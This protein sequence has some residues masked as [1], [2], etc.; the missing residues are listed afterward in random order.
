MKVTSAAGVAC[1]SA[2]PCV[3]MA[4]ESPN[5][6]LII[7]DDMGIEASNCY[8][9]GEQQAK[10]PNIESMCEQ[11]MVFE[12][13]Y[14]APVCSPTRATIMTGEYGFRNGV[15]AAIPRRG[16]EGRG[17]SVDSVSLFDVLEDSDYS[18]NVIG[19]WHL[20]DSGREYDHP[21]QLGVPDYWGL[22]KGGTPSYSH[23]S[24][25]T[26]GKPFESYVYTT[27][28]FT[29]QALEWIDKQDNPWFLWLAYNAPHTPFHL[30]PL[31]LHTSDDLPDDPDA[32]KKT[33]LPYYNAM[34]EAMDTEIGRLLDSMDAEERKN[35][36]VMFVGDNGSPNQV[37]RGFYG[38]HKA[39]GTI[40]EGGTHV[41][42]IA[43]G[44]GVKEGR[45]EG[46][47]NTTD[48]YATVA[49]IAGIDVDLTDSYDFTPLLSG[50]AN[51]RDFIYVGH[52][53]EV[54]MSKGGTFGW[55]VREG[56]Y[57]SV[58][59]KGAASPELYDLSK[60][61]RELTD[62]LADGVSKKE[63]RIVNRIQARYQQIHG[64]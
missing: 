4:N 48:I 45:T 39:K 27:T 6:L 12:S 9:L 15:G 26:Q 19:K 40:Y 2:L 58:Q 64:S 33:P 13:A 56:D 24:G 28:D 5:V 60:D 55:A 36:I 63:Q 14:S 41:P 53:E 29:N 3:A 47:V 1:L 57:K 46:F 51:D 22:L 54:V 52:F 38:D 20:A 61:P 43:M 21:I 37:V 17:L 8:S 10:M 18:T 32:I 23:W 31:D 34:L 35:T 11:G 44:P 42:L 62:L 50:K 59:V 7:A 25:V 16:G 49:S 30:P